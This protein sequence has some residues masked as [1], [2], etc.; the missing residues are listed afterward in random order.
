M[1]E[2]TD[3]TLKLGGNKFN[4]FFGKKIIDFGK[5]LTNFGESITNT[6]QPKLI[7]NPNSKLIN[8]F[9]LLINFTVD[10]NNKHQVILQGNYKER[11]KESEDGSTNLSDEEMLMII[12][13]S[14]KIWFKKE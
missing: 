11:Y 7:T 12:A 1:K 6:N 4:V 9:T 10:L 13:D 5:F 14:E 2:I 3:G 8:P